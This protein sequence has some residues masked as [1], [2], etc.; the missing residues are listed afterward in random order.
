MLAL[1][2]AWPNRINDVEYFKYYKMDIYRLTSFD[3]FINLIEDGTIRLHIKVDIYTNSKHYSKTYDHG[4]G[5]AISDNDICKL[6][7]KCDI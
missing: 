3:Y 2:K 7:Y 4:C 1:V 5:F 6:Y